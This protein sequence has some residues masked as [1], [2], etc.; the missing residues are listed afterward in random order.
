MYYV[1]VINLL[2]SS[3]VSS[4]WLG[5]NY[6]NGLYS[7]KSGYVAYTKDDSYNGLW[8]NWNMIYPYDSS[9][10]LFEIKTSDVINLDTFKNKGGTTDLLIQNV[11]LNGK[12]EE[13]AFT[14]LTNLVRITIRGCQIEKIP[15]LSKNTK[16][17]ILNL[18][19]NK[20]T[21]TVEP[22]SFP[23]SITHIDLGKNQIDYVPQNMFSNKPD[24][25]ILS[26]AE[27]Q[28]EEVPYTAI[29]NSN[30]LIYLEMHNSKMI[31]IDP[32]CFHNVPNVFRLDLFSNQFSYLEQHLFT[33]M[34]KLTELRLHSQRLFGTNTKSLK[35]VNFDFIKSL[36]S[37]LEILY[38]SDNELSCYPHHIFI[39]ETFTKLVEIHIDNNV[40]T[41]LGLICLDGYSEDHISRFNYDTINYNRFSD[42]PNLKD[43]HIHQN[44]ISTIS[45]IAM[46]YIPNLIYM[47]FSNNLLEY[48]YID[49]SA[50]STATKLITL[51]ANNNGIVS[52]EVNT[53]PA[54][55]VTIEMYNNLYNFSPTFTFQNLKF[56]SKLRLDNNKIGEIPVDAFKGCIALNTLWMNGNKIKIILNTMLTNPPLNSILYLHDN[57]IHYIEDLFFKNKPTNNM[58]ILKQ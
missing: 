49:K 55:I 6:W 50:L 53:F 15:D 37:N 45:D 10:S 14:T 2:F 31:N 12:I 26:L 47:D 18:Q 22:A 8:N 32:G 39:G 4:G 33:N 21:L 24:L 54:S 16:L 35:S 43:L 57:Q 38:L 41:D 25:R 52:I 7:T 13:N 56:L 17:K 20:I 48:K 23:V 1:V 46:K 28:L 27:N 19:N 5:F 30:N 9:A 42:T 3:F 51:Y 29:Q 44:K 58:Y 36:G 34:P 11:N 40:I